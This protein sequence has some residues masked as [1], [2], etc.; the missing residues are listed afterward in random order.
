MEIQLEFPGRLRVDARIGDHLV[1]TD[2]PVR[3]G[4][5]GTAPAPF[6]LFLASIATCA[7][8]YA[9]QFCRKRELS[10]EGLGLTLE[11]VPDPERRRLG[12][13]R[14]RVKLPEGFPEKYETALQRAVDQCAVKKHILEPPEFEVALVRSARID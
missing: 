6:D 13:I 8:L 2:Q 1:P 10:T 7:G 11:T 9:Q 12:G 3:S 4:G 14:L 5:D